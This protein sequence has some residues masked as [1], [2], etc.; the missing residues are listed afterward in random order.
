MSTSRPAPRALMPPYLLVEDFL[1]AELAEA[2][3]DYAI[4]KEPDYV[5]SGVGRAGREG[6]V[7][8]NIR[9]SLATRDLGVF[10]P[11]LKKIILAAVPGFTERLQATRI[12]LPKLELQLVAHND[13]AFYKRHCDSQTG[14]AENGIRVLSAVYYFHRRPKGFSGGALRLFAIGDLAYSKFL[15]I[16]PAN[17]SLL[18]FPSWAPH[19]VRPV[20]CPSRAFAASRFA[21]NCWVYR[22]VA[23][24]GET[25]SPVS[26]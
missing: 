12:A 17:N 20:E 7:N 15:D 16:E 14:A 24:A 9:A 10:R 25:A 6:R 4:A 11:Q 2:L 8:L 13:G 18:V 26:E 1:D 23:R 21:I 22:G 19:E 3:L 5:Q